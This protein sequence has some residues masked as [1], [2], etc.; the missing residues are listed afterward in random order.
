MLNHNN[1]AIAKLASKENSRFTLN[2]ILVEPNQTVV[3]DG[4]LLAVVTGTPEADTGSPVDATEGPAITSF[5][6]PSAEALGVAVASKGGYLGLADIPESK[7]K[8]CK[9][10]TKSGSSMVLNIQ[11]LEGNYPDYQRVIPSMDKYTVR[12]KLDAVLVAAMIAQLNE[13]M[14]NKNE[15][16]NTFILSLAPDAVTNVISGPVILEAENALG[17]TFKGLIMPMRMDDKKV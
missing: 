16:K 13:F 15:S 7:N 11:P 12:V 8:E 6:C 10:N 1:F 5:I 2:G 9:I 4:H 3:T 14:K 17:Q